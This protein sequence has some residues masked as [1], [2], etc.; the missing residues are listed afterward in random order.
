MIVKPISREP[1]KAAFDVT[2]DVLEHDDGVVDHEAD[3]Q[4]QR[5]QRQIVDAV[6]HHVHAGERAQ[7]RHR[8]RERR[9]NRGGCVAQEQVDHQHDKDRRQHQSELDVVDRI[10]D[11]HRAVGHHV[12]FGG[13]RQFRLENGKQAFDRVD[14]LD[15][16]GV[17]L[18]LDA[19]DD[20]ALAVVPGGDLVV[21]DA[22]GDGRDVLEPHRCTVAIG[23]DDRFEVSGAVILLH[24]QR[25]ALVGA[26]ERADWRIGVGRRHRVLHVLQGQAFSRQRLGVGLDAERV[27]RGAEDVD[28]RDTGQR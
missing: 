13:C 27:L 21:F 10:A 14:H 17:G 4:R 24:L 1:R 20:R 15:G 26:H 8:Q 19:E 18:L 2:H 22:V 16:V 6:A 23:D 5:Q 25:E 11:R 12:E 3:G 9:D 7:D 28:Q